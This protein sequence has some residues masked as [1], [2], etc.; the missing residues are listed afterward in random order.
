ML[1][2][3]VTVAIVLGV[4][5]TVARAVVPPSPPDRGCALPRNAAWISVEWSAEPSRPESLRKLVT[6][7]ATH[8]LHYLY[9]YVTYLRADGTFNPTYDYAEEFVVSYKALDPDTTLLAWIGLPLAND[10]GLG[11]DGWID[12]S[13]DNERSKIVRF[14]VD[15]VRDTGFDGVHIDAETVHDDDQSFLLLLDEI[16][17]E[18]DQDSMLSVASGY[19]LPP[20]VNRNPLARGYKWSS[21]YYREVAS[22]VDQIATMTY[23]SRMPH[24]A[25]YRLWLYGQARAI[26]RH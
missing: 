24:P 15:L 1:R 18:L 7:A 14:V 26:E 13:D 2:L 5:L 19:W 21:E 23:D 3:F 12:L 16:R 11:V 25:L 6:D 10:R 9:P 4:L 20:V 17:R 22:R 8:G